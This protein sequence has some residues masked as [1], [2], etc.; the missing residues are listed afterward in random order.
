MNKTALAGKI[1]L[2]S[3]PQMSALTNKIIVI[4]YG[5]SAQINEELK[6]SFAKDIAL[7]KMIGI[8]VVIIHGGG[9][10][11]DKYL[12]R[13]NIQKEFKNGQRVTSHEAM[14]IVE[15]TLS[16]KI[17]KDL[18]SL[19][20]NEG[21]NAL[22]LS[23][24]DLGLIYAKRIANDNRTGEIIK[25]N[26]LS[27]KNMLDNNITPI[28]SPVANELDTLKSLNINADISACE[29]A[30]ALKA[31]KIIFLTDRSGLLDKN[32]D[33]IS[34]INV[35]RALELI[36]DGVIKDG[37]ITKINACI[38]ALQSGV[39]KVHIIDGRIKNVLLLELLTS[40]GIGTE[41]LN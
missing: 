15:M 11:I 10:D 39:Q 34:S 19:L 23:G 35:S 31:Y 29:I 32:E 4:K 33:L 25:C 28:I 27:L 20:L 16:G 30:K 13:L 38:N 26:I 8:K 14:E 21:V 12:E 6:A 17:N 2:D 18:V 1:I 24:R 41:I 22:G 7:L 37:M 5:G 36:Y 3:L 40:K 9:K